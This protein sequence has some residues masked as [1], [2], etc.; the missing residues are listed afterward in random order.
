M[1]ENLDQFLISSLNTH[2]DIDVES[3]TFLPLGAD[4]N[5][6]TYKAQAQDQT[7]YFVKLKR[8]HQH[9]ISV[10]I[11]ELL[12]HA[13]I[14]EIIPPV[15]TVHGQP[16]QRIGDFTLIVYPFIEGENG[17]SRNLTDTQW[18]KLG[19]TLRQIHEIKV[20]QSIQNRI[21]REAYSPKWRE[22]VRSFYSHIEADP[23]GDAIALN[24]L[25]F[26]KKNRHDHSP[27]GRPR[28]TASRKTP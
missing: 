10:S 18:L 26:M 6:S 2:Y 13:G 11:V 19:R 4:R 24:L 3:L 17:F 16:T 15:N 28:R 1:I 21:R 22:A 7:S 20:P 23:S 25:Q 9:D 5:A 8:G 14:Q 27:A 12:Q